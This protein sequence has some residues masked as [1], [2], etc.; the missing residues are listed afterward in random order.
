V[1][2]VKVGDIVVTSGVGNCVGG[3]MVFSEDEFNKKVGEVVTRHLANVFGASTVQAI[4]FYL[5]KSNTDLRHV[6]YEAEKV[7][8]ASHELFGFAADVIEKEMVKAAYQAFG[9]VPDMVSHDLKVA[10]ENLKDSVADL[11]RVEGKEPYEKN[12]IP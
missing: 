1:S 7:S 12:L 9:L 8:E 10:L 5:K 2:I 11:F 6:C 3:N 4:N